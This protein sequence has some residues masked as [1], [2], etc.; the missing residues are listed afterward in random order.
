[1]KTASFKK[2]GDQ[3]KE[4]TIDSIGISVISHQN[5]TG[6]TFPILY[7]QP[8][9]S[10]Y[11]FKDK[12]QKKLYLLDPSEIK[13]VILQMS[14]GRQPILISGNAKQRRLLVDWFGC[15]EL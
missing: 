4:F 1:M 15:E 11:K 5:W 14:N 6:M 10:Q 12:Y 2:Y 3:P 8:L 13:M 9:V 7:P